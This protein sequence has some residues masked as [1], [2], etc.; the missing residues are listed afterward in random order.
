M[1]NNKLKTLSWDDFKSLGN[2]DNAPEMPEENEKNTIK[3]YDHILRI[4]LDKKQR[5]GKE[6]T[7]I[8][9]FKGSEE[10]LEDLG[11]ML[12]SKCGVGGSVKDGE[13]LL[14]G[15][16]RDKVLKLLLDMGYKQTKKAGG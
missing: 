1:E 3:P 2:P 15:N 4:H 11:K 14:Q 10:A 7:L 13:I 9:G 16:H 5:G 6:V 12:K 8:R